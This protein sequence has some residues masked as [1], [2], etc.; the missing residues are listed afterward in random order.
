MM[1][2]ITDNPEWNLG[3]E[4]DEE[5]E[6]VETGNSYL[7]RLALSVRDPVIGVLFE[8]IPSMLSN[9]NWKIRHTAIMAISLVGEGCADVM[10][11]KLNEVINAMLPSFRDPHERVRWATCNSIGQ[12]ATDFAPSFQKKFHEPVI[13]S[14]IMTMND[15]NNPRVQSYAAAAI[16]NFAEDCKGKILIPY[17]QPLLGNLLQL[18]KSSSALP[19]EQAIT[20][21]GAVADCVGKAFTPVSEIYT[22][23]ILFFFYTNFKYLVYR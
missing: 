23:Y 10:K 5:D 16:I 9:E 2:Q 15:T 22:M 14:L 20:A 11:P 3:E 21:T 12:M 4:H 7:D 6:E 18:L 19:V 13:Q 17:L 1:S 8:N